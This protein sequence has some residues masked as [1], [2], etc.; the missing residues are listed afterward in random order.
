MSATFAANHGPDRVQVATL[1]QFDFPAAPH[2][3][4]PGPWS[5]VLPFSQSFAYAGA[6]GLCWEVAVRGRTNTT[7]MN[8][9]GAY[10][11]SSSPGPWSWGFTGGCKATGEFEPMQ[12]TT[13]SSTIQ[14]G[15]NLARFSFYG[16]RL[17][18]NTNVLLGLSAAPL[19][20]PFVLPGTAT[21][22]SGECSAA[23]DWALSVAVPTTAAGTCEQVYANV[24]VTNGMSVFS[25]LLALDAAANQWGMVL[26]N[27]MQTHVLAPF[28]SPQ[29]GIVQA[30]DLGPTGFASSYPLSFGYVVRFH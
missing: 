13:A 23:I 24:P 28:P 22:P 8:F 2:F 26:S 25:Q 9:D 6:T 1:R 7:G 18:R 14:W 29:F 27:G 16:W 10:G 4:M 12:L 17:P 30:T 3:V 15:P 21:A 20:T 11:A 5:F 19:S